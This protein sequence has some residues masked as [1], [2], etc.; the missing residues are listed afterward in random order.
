MIRS[1][2]RTSSKAHTFFL[3]FINS[4]WLLINEDNE[5]SRS[6]YSL[7]TTTELIAN[8]ALIGQ[9]LWSMRVYTMMWMPCSL[10]LVVAHD[11][12]EDRY[13]DDITGNLFSLFCSKWGT[14]LKIFVWLFGIKVSESIKR[15]EKHKDLFTTWVC[16]EKSPVPGKITFTSLIKITFQQVSFPLGSFIFFIFDC[17][18]SV[19]LN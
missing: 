6:C 10:W 1:M 18:Q 7:F 12:S 13:M 19:C 14:V 4:M 8:H 9:E 16:Q 11:L 15:I 5:Q 3:Y 17:D 2:Y